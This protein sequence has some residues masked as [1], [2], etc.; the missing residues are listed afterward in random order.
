[1]R[2]PDFFIV[3]APKCGTTSLASYLQ[4]HEHVF[5]PPI[6]E[7]HYFCLDAP[8]YRQVDTLETYT[9][10]FRSAHPDQLCGEASTSYMFSDEAIPAILEANPG[11]KIIAMVRNPIT[12]VTSLHVQK[13]YSLEENEP[14]FETAWRLSTLRAQGQKVHPRCR[15]PRYMNYRDIGRLG[16]QVQ[17]LCRSVPDAQLHVIV[18]DDLRTNPGSVYRD[19][20]RFLGLRDD[21]RSSFGALNA[22]KTHAVPAL[23]RLLE[24]SPGRWLKLTAKRAFPA[25]TRRVGDRFHRLNSRPVGRQPISKELRREMALAFNDDLMLLGEILKRDLRHWIEQ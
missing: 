4:A 21:G 11:A 2:I 3:G 13:L 8:R 5:M 15:A 6:K 19:T 12:M 1:M 24:S 14:D 22:R 17:R 7:P 20:L 9:W 10:L 25:L 23:A 16:A 18:F